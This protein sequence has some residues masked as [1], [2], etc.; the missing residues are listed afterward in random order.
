MERFKERRVEEERKGS[1]PWACGGKWERG[2]EQKRTKSK[3]EERE[4]GGKQPLI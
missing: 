1:R 4:E 2:K 3:R